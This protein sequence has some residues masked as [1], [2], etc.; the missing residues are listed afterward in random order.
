MRRDHLDA[1]GYDRPTAP[2]ITA[3][4]AT[5]TRFADNIS[6]G[7]WTK[8]AVPALL[9]LISAEAFVSPRSMNLGV[10]SR[11]GRPGVPA[12][13]SMNWGLSSA[14]KDRMRTRAE[15]VFSAGVE[16][17]YLGT[18]KHYNQQYRSSGTVP[19][20]LSAPPP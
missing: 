12:V 20:Y 2:T 6:Q 7:S 9:T 17:G 13:R 16:E 19:Y 10:T 11:A 14:P 15:T 18:R 5:G 4:A 3:L 1:W 8:V